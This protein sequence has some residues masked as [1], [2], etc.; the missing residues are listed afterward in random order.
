MPADRTSG[1]EPTGDAPTGEIEP[2]GPPVA[3]R[4][5]FAKR[6]G[7]IFATRIFQFALALPTS[8][9][10]SR[11][12][13]P[14][15][16]GAYVAVTTLP[17]M[18]AA[19][20]LLGLPNAINYFAGRGSS[21]RSL[22][23]ASLV[24]TLILSVLLVGVVWISLPW[25]ETTF[26]RAAPDE[27]AR[28]ILATV[29][30]SMLATFGGSLLYGR[31]TI[32]TYNIVLIGQSIVTL[33]AA[34]LFVGVLGLGIYGAVAGT[35]VSTTFVAVGVTVIVGRLDRR[36]RSGQPAPMRAL[37]SYGGRVYPASVTGYFNYRADTYL[38]QALLLAPGRALGLYS[39]AVTFAELI[40]YVPD[41]I[42]TMLLPRVAGASAADASVIV[43]RVGRLT[44]LITSAAAVALIPAAIVGI[45]VV[46]PAYIDSIPAFLVL[47]PGVV[48]LSLAKI[49]TS[50]IS[51]RGRPG[52]VSVGAI[53]AL[54]LNIS[55]NLVLI[56]MLGIVGA[57]LA[58]LASY[59]A[60]ATMML[61]AAGRLAG[62]PVRSLFLPGAAELNLLATGFRRL[63]AGGPNRFRPVGGPDRREPL[64]RR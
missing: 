29:P 27:L 2:Q 11:L 49:M 48:S 39:I 38:I 62:A 4:G 12:L 57:S 33:A 21:M 61:V 13:G 45:H 7:G 55:L 25:L 58:S 19:L 34:V 23:R 56:P 53:A 36:D 28:V 9:L 18:L 60:L 41:S 47:L 46:L 24:F 14:T 15:D 51:G 16:K 54:V 52:I 63:R 20:G 35:V 43:G 64:S 59:T 10:V 3:V 5:M 22:V 1:G 31:Q 44:M 32:R 40:F 50:Y 26:L 17:G 30:M 8:I 6:V 37:L 42:S